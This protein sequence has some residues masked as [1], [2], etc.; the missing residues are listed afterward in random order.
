MFSLDIRKI[1]FSDS[2]VKHRL[3][4][5]R[6][7]VKSGSLEVFKKHGDVAQGNKG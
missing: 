4:L 3:R 1:F 7:A 6:E 2:V 5:L